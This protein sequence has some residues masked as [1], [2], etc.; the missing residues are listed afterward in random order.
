MRPIVVGLAAG[1]AL[2]AQAATYTVCPSSCAYATLGAALAATSN[3]DVLLL[4]KDVDYAVDDLV[5][6]DDVTIKLD[7]ASIGVALPYVHASASPTF[8]VGAGRKVIFQDVQLGNTALAVADVSIVVAA[9]SA[10]L[11]FDRVT[12]RAHA[13][14]FNA[15]GVHLVDSNGAT[16]TDVVFGVMSN[17]VPGTPAGGAAVRGQGSAI[18][19]TRVTAADGWS[20]G[21]GGFL[22]Q[23]LG[24]LSIADSSFVGWDSYLSGGALYTANVAVSVRNTTFNSGYAL[25]NGG[26]IAV[27]DGSLSLIGSHLTSNTAEAGSAG[28]LLATKTADVT[29][30]SSTFDTN[31]ADNG[32]GG[33]IEAYGASTPSLFSSTFTGNSARRGG[34]VDASD[35]DIDVTN[36]VFTSNVATAVPSPLETLGGG[37]LALAATGKG[38]ATVASIRGS[39]FEDNTGADGGAVWAYG[40]LQALDITTSKMTA[41]TATRSG[42]ALY[43]YPVDSD[44]NADKI[45]VV[46]NTFRQSEATAEGGAVYYDGVGAS[47]DDFLFDGNIVEAGNGSEG[48]GVWLDFATTATVVRNRICDND[49]TS[50]VGGGLYVGNNIA[51]PSAVANN[52]VVENRSTKEGGGVYVGDSSV[53]VNNNDLL[54]NAGASGKGGGLRFAIDAVGVSIRNN[55][56]GLQSSGNGVSRSFGTGTTVM[57]NA[58]YGNLAADYDVDGVGQGLPTSNFAAT[59]P[60]V[61]FAYVATAPGE[62]AGGCAAADFRVRG[63]TPSLINAGD[64]TGTYNDKDATFNDV[65][66]FGGPYADK[67]WWVDVDADGSAWVYDCNDNE[68]TVKPGAAELCNGR[69]DDCD[70]LVDEG[71]SGAVTAYLDFDK[72]GYG[73]GTKAQVATCGATPVGYVLNNL[74]CND[75]N[76][77]ISPASKEQC[78]TVAVDDDCDGFKDEGDAVDPY[79]FYA[80]TDADKYG[81]LSVAAWAC[82]APPGFVADRTD[83]NDKSN[84]IYPTALE[85]CNSVDDDCDGVLDDSAEEAKT[86]YRDGDGDSYGDALTPT[87]QCGAPVGY[88]LSSDDCDDTTVLI[89]PVAAEVCNGRDDDCDGNVDDG[90]KFGLYYPDGDGDG[91]GTGGA[92]S[93]CTPIEGSS[94]Q[95]G[96]CDDGDATIHPLAD[97]VCDHVD[98]DCDTKIDDGLAATLYFPDGDGDGHGDNLAIGVRDCVAPP[99][100]VPDDVDCDDAVSS[101]Y[102]G[103]PEQCNGID[104]DCDGTKDDAVQTIEWYVDLDGDGFGDSKTRVTDCKQPIGFVL[105]RTDCDDHATSVSPTASERCD[106]VDENCD[107]LVDNDAADAPTWFED[108]DGDGFG[109]AMAPFRSCGS[110]PPEGFVGNRHDC[111]DGLSSVLDGVLWHA[112]R[113]GDKSGDPSNVVYACSQPPGFIA[114]GNDC[115]DADKSVH[116]GRAEWCATLGIDDDCDGKI[117][118]AD[119]DLKDAAVWYRDLD[120]DG[121]GVS[122]SF[123]KGCAR[124]AN[125]SL[126]NT[127]CDDSSAQN[128]PGA[129]EQCDGRDNDCDTVIDDEVAVSAWWPDID[130]DGYG[131]ATST[132]NPRVACLALAGEVDNSFDCDDLLAEINP[133]APEVCDAID[134]DCDGQIDDQDDGVVDPTSWYQDLDGDNFGTGYD[135]IVACAAPPEHAAAFGDCWDSAEE[136]AADVRPGGAEVCDGL[137]NDCDGRTDDETALQIVYTDAD[138]DGYGDT[139]SLVEQCGDPTSGQSADAGDCDDGDSDRYPGAVE[140]Y[141]DGVDQNCDGASD[142][143]QDEDGFDAE[144]KGGTDCED[145]D[146]ARNPGAAEDPSNDVDD[147]CD[148]EI[149]EVGPQTDDRPF[150]TDADTDE[151][152]VMGEGCGCDSAGGLGWVGLAVGLLLVRRRR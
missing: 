30:D 71:A 5:V 60:P 92:K 82:V 140:S 10:V 12:F 68:K 31:T 115:D 148:G 90:V 81:D 150:D 98:Q 133:N 137:D 119:S 70:A 45:N 16:F 7:P 84:L 40:A 49:A 25:A 65:G 118:D 55:L 59:V 97:E 128:R 62:D 1:L 100:M 107:D 126:L 103:A 86:S 121:F 113:D 44:R 41:N 99:T 102:G 26:A 120:N 43:L 145:A 38:V 101:T 132:K 36:C 111:N 151:V 124:P 15:A 18:A 2:P 47:G 89:S 134:N 93:S 74:D 28:A 39:T 50:S 144:S 72:D 75:A 3:G 117:D 61:F 19:M 76:K 69:D 17:G 96:D 29:I 141:Y 56:V 64:K 33:A 51:S 20:N 63:S 143:D 130:A 32:Y 21:R 14:L 80:D 57:Y 46:G 85:H 94:Q 106:G 104:D 73:D 139:S 27:D 54:A 35:V 110:T 131:D 83:C 48:G 79:P 123:T 67:A 109:D 6:Q 8:R 34:A 88:V 66:A 24:T 136:G 87:V 91:Y 37:A 108:A 112:D 122:A 22:Y 142:D 58:F 135:V 125:S 127:D 138:G 149:D 116:P 9:K 78:A 77:L 13:A 147:D 152:V 23:T 11:T 95:T 53:A 129:P 146:A 42:G 4:K 52:F 105:D 114:D